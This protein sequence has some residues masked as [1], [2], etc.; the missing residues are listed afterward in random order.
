MCSAA[1]LI[2]TQQEPLCDP[3]EP[4]GIQTFCSTFFVHHDHLL[5][6]YQCACVCVAMYLLALV[7]GAL[8]GGSVVMYVWFKY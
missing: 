8:I 7:L 3:S 2:V 6:A 1:R 5:L 4:V